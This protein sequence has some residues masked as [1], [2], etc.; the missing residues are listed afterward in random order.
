M[1]ILSRCSCQLLRAIAVR[2]LATSHVLDFIALPRGG[3]AA[4]RS[5][6]LGSGDV[7]PSTLNRCRGRSPHDADAR[8]E[9]KGLL[10]ESLLEAKDS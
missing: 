8:A 4:Q 3:D 6:V 5:A 1:A 10:V 9:E 7:L 2:R